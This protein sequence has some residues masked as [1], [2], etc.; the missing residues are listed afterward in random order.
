MSKSEIID[1][2]ECRFNDGR[3]ECFVAGMDAAER[4][5]I[6]AIRDG[7]KY[8]DL[9]EGNFENFMSNLIN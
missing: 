2:H 5:V 4:L 1:S 9:R 8:G 3:C 7:W 6:E